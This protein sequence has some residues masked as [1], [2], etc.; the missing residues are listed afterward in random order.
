[1]GFTQQGEA[2]SG[3]GR[4]GVTEE[5]AEDVG[6]ALGEEGSFLEGVRLARCDEVS[7]MLKAG[8]GSADGFRQGEDM[9]LRTDEVWIE[10]GLGFDGHGLFCLPKVGM[11][12]MARETEDEGMLVVVVRC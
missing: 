5:L 4:A 10:K 11:I 7:P 6:E 8:L 9:H 3:T 1:M 12:R 2:V